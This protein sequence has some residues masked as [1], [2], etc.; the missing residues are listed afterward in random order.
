MVIKDTALNLG[1]NHTKVL[2]R[3]RYLQN[4]EGQ[5]FVKVYELIQKYKTDAFFCSCISA[6]HLGNPA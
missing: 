1:G 6:W 3:F 5:P 4:V 2:D